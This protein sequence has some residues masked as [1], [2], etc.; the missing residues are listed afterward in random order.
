MSDVDKVT[1]AV[2]NI[3]QAFS[4]LH[5]GS[6]LH[7]EIARLKAKAAMQ[8][9]DITKLIAEKANL[10][11]EYESLRR[12]AHLKIQDLEYKVA[13]F[14]ASFSRIK[15]ERDEAK[16][17]NEQFK[18]ATDELR[19]KLWSEREMGAEAGAEMVKLR[20][21]VKKLEKDAKVRGT[22]HTYVGLVDANDKL[23]KA[24]K[25]TSAK[26]E[27]VQTAND[28][29]ARNNA[30]LREQKAGLEDANRRNAEY[31]RELR[32]VIS[33]VQRELGALDDDDE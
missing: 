10:K 27:R 3:A 25:E 18:K 5:G 17:A 15:K 29:L 4:D 7:E 12:D 20:E 26:L 9:G 14:G 23:A 22:S 24:H 33:G 19:V 21:K 31:N 28:T 30:R 1:E 6:E 11:D 16:K 8:A 13:E 32:D 2:N